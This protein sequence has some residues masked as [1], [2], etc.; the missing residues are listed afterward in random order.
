MRIGG[1][2]KICEILVMFF[3]CFL[4]VMFDELGKLY[5]E[6]IIPSI[7]GKVTTYGACGYITLM[8]LISICENLSAIFPNAKIL[9]KIIK[10]LDT[11]KSDEEE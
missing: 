4:G 3:I 9:A 11:I 10:A 5:N 6:P 7:S 8:E 1:V 2:H